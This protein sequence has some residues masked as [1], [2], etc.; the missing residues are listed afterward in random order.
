MGAAMPTQIRGIVLLGRRSFVQEHFGEEGWSRV[1]AA[2]A[3]Q[4]RRLFDGFRLL[5]VAWYPSALGE[6][7]DR[8]IVDVLGEGDPQVFVELGSGSARNHLQGSHRYFLTPGDPQAFLRKVPTIY[9]LYYD[10][11]R[12]EYEQTGPRSGVMT[13]FDAEV[14]SQPDCLT[15]VGWYREALKMCGAKDVQI[16]EERC[17]ARGDDR[18]R[19]RITWGG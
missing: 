4:D 11:G 17:R 2:L 5:P 14:F 16:V 1:L 12:R 6:R 7:L 19:Y 3:P 10:S 13:T 18:C 8:A 9:D 15:V